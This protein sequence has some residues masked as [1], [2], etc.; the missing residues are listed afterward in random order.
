MATFSQNRIMIFFLLLL[1]KILILFPNISYGYSLNNAA[2]ILS[3]DIIPYRIATDSFKKQF[4][5]VKFKEYLLSDEPK[6]EKKILEELK[7]EKND[8][9]LGV[10]P[11][12]TFFLDK[13][14]LKGHLFFAMVLNPKRLIKNRKDLSGVS[15]NIPPE[16]QLSLIEK[17]SP[18]RSSIGIFFSKENNIKLLNLYKDLASKYNLKILG[19]PINSSKEIPQVLNSKE[20]K[21]EIL[22]F[23]PDKVVINE[24][25]VSY[26]IKICIIKKIPVIG[27]NRWFCK[28]GAFLSF[29]LNYE[30][31]GIQT[32]NLCKNFLK[33]K[34]LHPVIEPPKKIRIIINNK[35]ADKFNFK[36]SEEIKKIADEL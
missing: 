6:K 33:D 10:G 36:I 22:L 27:F 20:F 35:I 8:L 19:F 11:E 17:A 23:I 14:N 26:I 21:T 5:E 34:S 9:I 25:L 31:I 30:D 4:T 18:K 28:N 32:G 24:K 12:A 16:L 1:I 15:L 2:I 13:S 29:Y 7:E 3:N